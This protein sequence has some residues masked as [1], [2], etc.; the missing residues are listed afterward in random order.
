MFARPVY[1]TTFVVGTLAFVAAF[2]LGIAQAWQHG[3]FLPALPYDELGQARDAAALGDV[4]AA[5]RQLRTYAALQP[6]KADGW[7]RLGQFLQAHGDAAGA[8]DAYEHAAGSVGGPA[9]ADRQ[10][11]IL[12]FARGDLEAARAHAEVAVE[13][14]LTLPAEVR[15]GLGMRDAS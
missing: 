7:M 6:A 2:A 4:D 8:I 11:A 3:G 12:Q 10:L 1:G 14:G 9:E 5:A 13:Y 15:R